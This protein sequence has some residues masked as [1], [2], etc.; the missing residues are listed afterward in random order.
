MNI[1]Q[2]I[3]VL[4]ALRQVPLVLCQLLN[5]RHYICKEHLNALMG[6]LIHTK[7]VFSARK[8]KTPLKEWNIMFP[9]NAITSRV[10]VT[11]L[12]FVMF[13]VMIH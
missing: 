7:L 1:L 5:G 9:H 4:Q 13:V 8:Y 11:V 12:Y 2:E 6:S 10:D 3:L